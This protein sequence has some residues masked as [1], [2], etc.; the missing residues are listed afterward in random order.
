MKKRFSLLA[1][2]ALLFANILPI[3]NAFATGVAGASLEYNYTGGCAEVNIG[4]TDVVEVFEPCVLDNENPSGTINTNFDYTYDG[5]VAVELQTF[6]TK[7][8]TSVVINDVEYNTDA[9]FP[10]TPAQILEKISDQHI[11]YR[12]TV[13]HSA[14]GYRISTTAVENT[15]EYMTVGNFLWSYE[16]TTVMDNYVGHGKLE[17][18][19]VKYNGV[20]YTQAELNALNKG[21]AWWNENPVGVEGAAMLPY[22][23]E[24]TVKLIPDAGYQLTEFTLNG[25]PFAAQED[26]GTYK[27]TIP[28]GNFHLGAHFTKV[29]DAVKADNADAITSGSITLGGNEFN[30]GTA[31][32][33]VKNA[34]GLDPSDIENFQGNAEG[35]DLKTV[36]DISLFNTIYKA[37]ANATWDTQLDELNHEATITLKL[38][39]SVD[40]NDVI[41]VHEKHDG[42]YEVIPTVYDPVNHTITFKTS[43]FSNYAIATRTIAA[44][45][46]GVMTKEGSSV[47][48]NNTVIA[49]IGTLS[50]WGL[51]AFVAK[52]ALND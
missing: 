43:S 18:I 16:D 49:I 51:L 1:A 38:D 29:N 40:G 45:N 30:N 47:V 6:F 42:T 7:R 20:N 17:L 14:T 26:I 3:T 25:F 44:P 52:K 28:R 11:H 19:N 13:P 23:A 37:S 22:G 24:V 39:P 41:I 32:L 31:R 9:N 48:E 15:G 50:L 10:T 35:Y 12:L 36:L 5:T 46:T 34:E 27:F 21:Y 4:G 33:E 2:I 8:L